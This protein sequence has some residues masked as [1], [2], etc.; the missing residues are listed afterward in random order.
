VSLIQQNLRRH[1]IQSATSRSSGCSLSEVSAPTEVAYLRTASLP[2]EDVIRLEV[3]MDAAF[4]M[5]VANTFD[6][7][8]INPTSSGLRESVVRMPL[9]QIK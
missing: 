9:E 6:D 2:E 5:E 1:I 8:P 7:L 4:A 3:S